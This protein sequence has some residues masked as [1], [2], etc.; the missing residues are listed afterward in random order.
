MDCLNSPLE[1]TQIQSLTIN[2]YRLIVINEKTKDTLKFE[3]ESSEQLISLSPG[4]FEMICSRGTL[5]QQVGGVIIN[6]NSI[7]FYDF[8]LP[9]QAM[10]TQLKRKNKR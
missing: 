3:G 7:T 10:K 8:K 2:D 6:P 1:L 4:T 9:S 5:S